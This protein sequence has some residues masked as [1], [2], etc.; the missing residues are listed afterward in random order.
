MFENDSTFTNYSSDIKSIIFF[1]PE[2]IYNKNANLLNFNKSNYYLHEENI[3]KFDKINLFEIVRKKVEL[4]MNHGIYGFCIYYNLDFSVKINNILQILQN[5]ILNFPFFIIW[6]NENLESININSNSSNTE[7]LYLKTLDIF[8]NNTKKYIIGESYIKI[9]NKPILSINRPLII[10][11]LNEFI[12]SLREKAKNSE[13]GDIFI[14]FPLRN[15]NES[16]DIISLF[17]GVYDLTNINLIKENNSKKKDLFYTGIIY[18]NLILNTYKI[19]NKIP[20]YRTSISEINNYSK[21]N[22][23][24]GYSPYKFYLLNKILIKWT[25]RNH[26]KNN[27]LIFIMSWNNYQNSNYLEPDEKYGYASLNAFSKALFNLSYNNNRMILKNKCYVAIQAHVY[28]EDLINE[29]I[30]KTNNIPVKFDLYITTISYE[31]KIIIEKYV[32]RYSSSDKYEIKIV[33]NKGRDVLPLILQLK[34]KIKR[35]KYFCHIHTKK[36]KHLLS[37]GNKWRNYLYNNLLGSKEIINEILNDFELFDNLGFVFPELYYDLFKDIDGFYYTDCTFHQPNIKYMNFILNK[38][39]PKY[40]I[41]NKIN[42][43]AGNMFWA[44]VKAVYQIFEIRFIKKFPKELNQTNDSI[45]HAIER[46]W[47]YLVKLNGYYYKIIFK[48]F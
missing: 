46:I 48:Y 8:I 15:I 19:K 36:S 30:N 27:R 35:Y 32:K 37:F 22:E 11:N 4:A 41:G 38:I 26:K 9:N 7:E 20:F 33:E 43:P 12:I 24:K 28:Y 17:D 29:I 14:F 13:I 2:Y 34:Y 5:K 6:K 10:P 23:L 3:S 18:N 21:R 47:L 31:K 16:S 45:M 1:Y 42:F 44:K 39:N 40:K 25:K